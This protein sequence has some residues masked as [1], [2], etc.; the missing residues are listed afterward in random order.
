MTKTD[1]IEYFGSGVKVAEALNIQP[2]AVYQWPELVP[3]RRA[4]EIQEI[5]KGKLKAPKIKPSF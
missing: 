5:T 1:V 4:Y 2:A 3:I